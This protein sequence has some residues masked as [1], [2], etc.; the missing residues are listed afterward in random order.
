MTMAS[1]QSDLDVHVLSLVTEGSGAAP[2]CMREPGTS[3]F[4]ALS[5]LHR[6]A[7]AALDEKGWSASTIEDLYNHEGVSFFVVAKGDVL[8]AFAIVRV[9][10]DEAELLTIVT[11]PAVQNEGLAIAVLNK[12]TIALKR[13]RIDRLFLEVRSDNAPALGLYKKAG[14][15]SMGVRKNYYKTTAGAIYDAYTLVKHIR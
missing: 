1:G 3:L 6:A 14:F 15:Q 2:I 12:I 5:S 4:E 10:A 11:S 7:F 13:G 9:A 8:K